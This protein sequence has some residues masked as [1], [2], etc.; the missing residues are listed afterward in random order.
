VAPAVRFNV[1]AILVTPDFAFAIVFIV[2]TS[3]LVHTRRIAFLAFGIRSP[4]RTG[5]AQ[6][7]YHGWLNSDQR[8]NVHF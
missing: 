2:R 1:F 4:N 8:T 3:S 5:A 7:F 6:G